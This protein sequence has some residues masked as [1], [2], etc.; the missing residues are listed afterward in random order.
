LQLLKNKNS[1]LYAFSVAFFGILLLLPL[2]FFR[3][4]LQ[5]LI[6]I[7]ERQLKALVQEKLLLEAEN[8]QNDINPRTFVENS[9]RKLNSKFNLSIPEKSHRVFQYPSGYDPE[10]IDANFI[11]AAR[12]YLKE[13]FSL[14]PDIL[15]A[16]DCDLQNS[17]AFFKPDALRRSNHN[18]KEKNEL[19][20]R[21]V[22]SV[23]CNDTLVENILPYT[24][25]LEKRKN[26]FITLRQANDTHILF[27]FY[28]RHLV[29]Y[30]SN[31][32]VYSDDCVKFFSNTSGNQ[33]CYA[34]AHKAVKYFPK[35]QEGIYGLYF[36]VIPGSSFSP[37][38][39]LKNALQKTTN[40]CER[41]IVKQKLK[42]PQ[43]YETENGIYYFAN[44][45]SG[46]F[47][48]IQDCGLK[49]PEKEKFFR[50]FF[51]TH[52][53][54]TFASR[55]Q[56]ISTNRKFLPLVNFIIKILILFIFATFTY[57]FIYNRFTSFNLNWKLKTTIALIVLI[58][59][60]GILFVVRLIN[61]ANQRNQIIKI[62]NHIQRKIKHLELLDF[63]N[64]IRTVT[65][66]LHKKSI[67]AKILSQSKINWQKL[68]NAHRAYSNQE[69]GVLS[70]FFHKNGN[71]I[72]FNDEMKV[73]NNERK[74]E[75]FGLLRILTDLGIVDFSS[76]EVRKLDKEQYL[77]GTYA[78]PLFEVLATSE[79]LA[80]EST[81][82]KDVYAIS[83][84]K[85]CLIQLVAPPT[86]PENPY[87]I[88]YNEL[89]GARIGK[90]YLNHL[91]E[92]PQIKS[93]ETVSNGMIEYGAFLRTNFGLRK[94]KWPAR[95]SV[96][97]LHQI[98]EKAV[99]QRSSGSITSQ[100]GNKMF[101]T[102]WS[103]KESSPVIIVA[104]AVLTG[105]TNKSLIVDITPW[106]LLIYGLIATII[107]SNWLY[108][109]FLNPVELLLKGVNNVSRGKY[110]FG[111]F[112]KS[113]DEFSHLVDSF[114]KMTGGL[115]QREKMKR[116]VSDKLYD[117][118]QDNSKKHEAKVAD[119]TILSSDI[120]DFTAISEKFKAEQVVEMLND[121]LTL[122]ERAIKACGGTIEKI[123]GDAII[124]SFSLADTKQRS[125]AACR[126]AIEMRKKLE[127]FNR[128]RAKNNL[129]TIENGIGISD[130][131]VI[132]GFAG[133]EKGRKEFIISG[134][135]LR[136][137]DKL[138]S[139]SKNGKH[140][141]IIIDET[142][143]PYLSNKFTLV[144]MFKD[145]KDK[146]WEIKAD[147]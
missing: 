70:L 48:I 64:D 11:T 103:F 125:I 52:S 16:A 111:L 146:A 13:N 132:F 26:E 109:Y 75:K 57:T 84:L 73:T 10:L 89:N 39:V 118:I 45:T 9:L 38:I 46:F 91:K 72:S 135:P 20:K 134:I 116:F 114:N 123:I 100:K 31:P 2:I 14:D 95:D 133:Q 67:D 32:P 78:D 96:R 68:S 54:A 85:R 18:S 92:H 5:K 90:W 128:Q 98:A 59:I 105:K 49:Y 107:I 50:Q 60:I 126:A 41:K 139:L 119:I 66:F 94:E 115:L 19:I 47:Q 82:I 44:F 33:R 120:R 62:R 17:Y 4:V 22:F 71:A 12:I 104:R 113:G 40:D 56:L 61:T 51:K 37:E 110:G 138:E 102:S 1:G 147:V 130:G 117:S 137:A 34:Y 77:F 112:L 88:F 42:Q 87:G 93:V 7:E 129:F 28:F 108:N 30:F 97:H 81:I 53:L 136:K 21:A 83:V 86:N 25:S 141:K 65:R 43:F 79:N 140:S 145:I 80:A 63:E 24:K 76:P 101:L 69:L 124:A 121:Y 23:G 35:N 74:N 144:P 131:K 15:I 122:M 58:P 27:S 106:L 6:K 29:S 142:I 99:K 127:K 3:Q 8:F 36:L 143:Y 55:K